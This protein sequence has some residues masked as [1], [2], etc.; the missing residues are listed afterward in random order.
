M[1]RA[2]FLD[3]DGVINESY[4][5]EGLPRPPSN[6][7]ELNIINGVKEAIHIL[8]KYD[9]LPVVITNQPDVSRGTKSADEIIEINKRI[10]EI[11]GIRYFYTCTHDDFNDCICRKPKPG[12]VL[13]AARELDI[14]VSKSFLVGDRWRDIVLGQDLGLKTYFIDYKYLEL[15]PKKPYIKVDSL[16]EAVKDVVRNLDDFQ[17][18]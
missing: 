4:I 9:F 3:R 16:L 5:V 12:L 13:Q 8:A 15:A 10:S 7:G 6:I 14:D 18:E 17:Y 11:T 1:K 2:A